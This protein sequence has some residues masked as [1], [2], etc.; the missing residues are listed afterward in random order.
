MSADLPLVTVAVLAYNRRDALRISLTKLRDELDWPA[1]R[2]EV[3][4]VDNASTDGTADMVRSEFGEVQ[5]IRSEVNTGISGWN[6]AFE[7]G[8][9][10]WFLV[11]DD[12]CYV[13][14]DALHRAIAG[15]REHEAD[16][17]SFKV[18][19]SDEDVQVFNE[20]YDTGLLAFW[21]CSALLSGRAAR[22]LGGFDPGIF[23]WGHE[24][25]FVARLLDRGWR[26]LH[27]PEIVSVHM[28]SPAGFKLAQHRRN[29]QSF[30][31]IAGKLLR[32]RDLLPAAGNLLLR[33]LTESVRRPRIITCM[34]AVAAGLRDGLRNRA[35][36]RPAVSQ[37]YR[38][39]FIEFSSPLY[40][41]RGPLLI[42]RQRRR[43][44]LAELDAG[45]RRDR[46]WR[47]R[48]ACYPQGTGT[49][50]V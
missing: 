25:E 38:R 47:E 13:T 34:P 44:D 27:L 42:W 29:L 15:A 18:R 12:D 23:I 37:L 36:V 4:V 41:A 11:L 28:K 33:V 30:G 8:T 1:E 10:D 7:A 39:N 16:L 32:P 50:S 24:A 14:G 20:F 43:D 2:L 5:L 6:R 21:G 40:F 19:S 35:P 9:G 49:L 45:E 46:F 26:H 17:V 22:E 48:A 3:I 31:Y